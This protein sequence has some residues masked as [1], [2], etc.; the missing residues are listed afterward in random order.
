M[1]NIFKNVKLLNKSNYK[2]SLCMLHPLSFGMEK[3]NNIDNNKNIE[4]NNINNEN[5][6]KN[7]EKKSKRFTI[8]TFYKNEFLERCKKKIINDYDNYLS[9]LK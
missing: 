6:N 1:L 7:D 9:N 2:V 3:N 8:E 4:N 5:N